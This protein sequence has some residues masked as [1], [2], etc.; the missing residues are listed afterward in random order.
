MN[1]ILQYLKTFLPYLELLGILSCLTFAL[2]ILI[3]PWFICRLP[4]DYFLFPQNR[5]L[6]KRSELMKLFLLLLRNVVGI[7]LVQAGILMLF[8]PGQGILTILIGLLCMSFPGKQHMIDYLIRQKALQ[9]SLNWTRRKLSLP[10][11]IWN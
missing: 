8:L 6:S 4:V 1:F 3:I 10:P 7:I 9:K 11:F 5:Q 2:S